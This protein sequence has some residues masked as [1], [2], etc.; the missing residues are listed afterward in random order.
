MTGVS[1]R[2][3]DLFS[4]IIKES[5][6]ALCVYAALPRWR[7]L[8]HIKEEGNPCFSHSQTIITFASYRLRAHRSGRLVFYFCRC[9]YYVALLK[10]FISRQFT[11]A[12]FFP[13]RNS[14]YAQVCLNNT[15]VV[16]HQQACR[17][18]WHRRQTSVTEEQ[19]V[20]NHDLLLYAMQRL[21]LGLFSHLEFKPRSHPRS[22]I[23]RFIAAIV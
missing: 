15:E 5:F 17:Q 7:H 2:E 11:R 13:P 6:G 8:T 22:D 20:F 9:C 21:L 1:H 4:L 10:P 12:Y 14:V 23:I 19:L 3:S 18:F 16:D